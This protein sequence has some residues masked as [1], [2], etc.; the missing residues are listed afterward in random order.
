MRVLPCA[1]ALRSDHYKENTNHLR[2]F[3]FQARGDG[4]EWTTLDERVKIPSLVQPGSHFL[5]FVDTKEYF[6]EFRVLQTGPSH[7]NF[8]SFNLSGIE[9]HGLV[10][11]TR[12]NGGRERN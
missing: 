3:V 10:E 12:E 1:Y 11:R 2:T 8:L 7:S 6:N 9:I 5:A 4:A